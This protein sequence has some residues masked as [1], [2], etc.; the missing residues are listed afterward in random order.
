MTEELSL[1][2]VS[3]ANTDMANSSGISKVNRLGRIKLLLKS[4]TDIIEGSLAELLEEQIGAQPT[5]HDRAAVLIVPGRGATRS[6]HLDN[7]VEN[8]NNLKSN[9]FFDIRFYYAHIL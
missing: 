9:D 5:M 7:D 8:Y 3:L 6:L 4:G 1:L 2:V